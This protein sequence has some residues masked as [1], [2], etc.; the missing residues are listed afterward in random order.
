MYKFCMLA[1]TNMTMEQ[2]SEV[3]M[4][5]LNVVRICIGRY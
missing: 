5:K 2:H 3:I 1:I 4:G